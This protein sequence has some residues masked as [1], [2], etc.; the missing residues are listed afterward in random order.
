MELKEIAVDVHQFIEERVTPIP[1][2]TTKTDFK[3]KL[4]ADLKIILL[5]KKMS[6]SDASMLVG[7]FTALA[8]VQ[9]R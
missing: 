1:D 2:W 9:F 6:M 7:Y 3:R 5:K 8:E 4:N